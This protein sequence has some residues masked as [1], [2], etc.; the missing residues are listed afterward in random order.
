MWRLVYASQPMIPVWQKIELL[1]TGG[2]F[3]TFSTYMLGSVE[4]FQTKGWLPAALNITA[5]TALGLLMLL[6]GMAAGQWL[7]GAGGS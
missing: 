5:A 4:L 1:A 2:V 6:A 7:P 3:T